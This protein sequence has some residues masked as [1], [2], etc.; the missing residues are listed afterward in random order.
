MRGWAPREVRCGSRSRHPAARRRKVASVMPHLSIIL[1]SSRRGRFADQVASWV[2][3]RGGTRSGVSFEVVDLR[4]HPLPFLDQPPPAY[5][6]RNYPNAHSARLGKILDRA[7][8]FLIL[9]PEYNHGYPAVLKNALDH[10]FVEWNRK[11]VAFVGWGNVGGARAI[12]QLRAVAVELE[13]AP[14]RRSV[15]ILPSVMLPI[16]KGERDAATALPQLDP[17]LDLLV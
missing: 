1:G 10:A 17:Q 7:D 14:V 8:G 6:G 16:M 15:H 9:T 13:M 11:P 5:T 12:E 2:A 4:D 3:S